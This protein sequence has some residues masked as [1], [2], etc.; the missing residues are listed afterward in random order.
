[1]NYFSNCDGL[2]IDLRNNIGGWD[3]MGM[4]LLS[5]FIDEDE[6]YKLGETKS[7]AVASVDDKGNESGLTNITAHQKN[8]RNVD[9]MTNVYAVP[10]PFVV[11]SGFEGN[12]V[13]GKIGFYGLPEECTIRIFSYAGQLIETI[14]H[15]SKTFSKEWF[16]VTRNEQ[17][18]ASGI[19]F[20][21]V[22]TPDGNSVNGKLI[23]IK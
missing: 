7:Y 9:T 4:F 6:S 11:K 1:M 20:Y 23:V 8:V 19:Y 21:V 12:N 22:T 3:E 13:D 18:I 10:N 14:E 16:Q 5:Y 15:N 2:I 17:D